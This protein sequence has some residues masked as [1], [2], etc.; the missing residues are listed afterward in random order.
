[1]ELV[2]D[3]QEE[4]PSKDFTVIGKND[5]LDRIEEGVNAILG[6][7]VAIHEKVEEFQGVFEELEKSP[8][9]GMLFN[10]LGLKK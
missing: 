3:T 8:A 5:Q 6:I 4:T 10:M 7:M 2:S 9:G 1:M